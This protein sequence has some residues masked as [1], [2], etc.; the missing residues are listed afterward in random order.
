VVHYEARGR[1]EAVGPQAVT[2]AVA[3]HDEQVG[4]G[5][6]RGSDY[7]SFEAAMACQDWHVVR[8]QLPGSS[9]ED[10]QSSNV[11]CLLVGVR[12]AVGASPAEKATGGRFG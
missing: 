10:L 2:F 12:E 1:A 11:G 4:T 3:C 5:L 8:P 7:L 9:L 6:C